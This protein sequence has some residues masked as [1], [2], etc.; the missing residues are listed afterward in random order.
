MARKVRV[1]FPGAVYHVMARGNE[2][3]RVFY[4]PED[5]ILFLTT[6]EEALSQFAVA[7]HA[8][9]LM[10]NHIHLMLE[11]PQGNLSRFMAWL[12]TTFTVRYNRRHGRSGHLFQGRYRAELV[13]NNHYGQWLVLYIHL[14]PIRTRSVK[15]LRYHG[16]LKELKAFIWSSHRAYI[17]LE[18]AKVKGLQMKRLQHWGAA[19]KEARRGYLKAIQRE[20]GSAEPLDW[21]SK[22]QM[23]LVAGEDALLKRV[24]KLLRGKGSQSGGREEG[25][26]E[27]KDRC[28]RL[29]P[30]LA[31]EDDERNR[32]WAQV[33]LLGQRP[34]DLA[35]ERGY[36]DGG[37]ILQIVK[38]VEKRACTDRA[39]GRKLN[40][41][42][43]LSRVED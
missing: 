35:R 8:Y 19:Q 30:V 5:H 17:G 41:W 12:Q 11:T 6:L 1:Q 2:R 33:R 43:K 34:V 16:G 42:Q 25:E 29:E 15:G 23:G 37:S 21:K 36:R 24:Q 22:I 10:P 4:N 14:N 9:C 27:Q 18:Q 39:L 20:L 28:S 7:L 26:L 3:A 32:I 31:R 13:D 40:R 38:R